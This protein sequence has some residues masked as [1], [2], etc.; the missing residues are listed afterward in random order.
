M[1]WFLKIISLIGLLLTLFPSFFVFMNIIDIEQNHT[2]MLIGT[3]FWFSSFPFWIDKPSK[4]K[5]IKNE[6]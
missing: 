6:N 1:R 2:L 5:E 3:I 4:K